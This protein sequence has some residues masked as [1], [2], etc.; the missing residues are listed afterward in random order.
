MG[1]CT[2]IL[3]AVLIRSAV[4]AAAVKVPYDYRRVYLYLY[5]VYFL[6]STSLG[7]RSFIYR[8]YA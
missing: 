8:L 2:L 6:C 1:K 4:L 5:C 7:C 3:R